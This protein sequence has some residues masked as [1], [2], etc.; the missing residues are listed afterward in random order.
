M[1]QDFSRYSDAEIERW[2]FLRAVEWSAW[3]A[4]LSQPIAP[5]LLIM[6]P[7]PTVLL[8]VVC[9]DLVWQCIQYGFVSVRLSKLSCLFVVLLKWPAAVGSS[10]YLLVHAKYILAIVALLWP[11]LAGL[12][13]SPVG[14]LFGLFRIRRGVG[15]IELALAKK[16]GYVRE[17][18]SL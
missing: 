7:W 12:L 4:F 14:M 16:I 15:T 13:G 3:T 11:A 8:V 18:A 10:I 5:V 17:D 2:L 9:S 6:L 1:L